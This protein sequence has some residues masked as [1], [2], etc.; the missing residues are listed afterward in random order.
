MS[1]SSSSSQPSLTSLRA[2]AEPIPPAPPVTTAT[3]CARP[4]PNIAGLPICVPRHRRRF[5]PRRG[6]SRPPGNRRPYAPRSR[7]RQRVVKPGVGFG[8][9]GDDHRV[10]GSFAGFAV[11]PVKRTDFSPIAIRA[12][13]FDAVRCRDSGIS[14]SMTARRAGDRPRPNCGSSP[15]R[16]PAGPARAETGNSPTSRADSPTGIHSLLAL[17]TRSGLR[18]PRPRRAYGQPLGERSHCS[19]TPQ[20]SARRDA[21]SWTCGKSLPAN[22]GRTPDRTGGNHDHVGRERADGRRSP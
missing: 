20:Q 15:P 1:Q 18:S 9:L 21:M 10:G 4:S 11:M 8:A 17:R 7:C 19:I 22:I 2:Q 13:A 12:G 6:Y 16:P 5:A 3:P 14:S